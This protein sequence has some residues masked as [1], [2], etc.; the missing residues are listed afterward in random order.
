MKRIGVTAV[1]L[2]SV[3][4]A[5]AQSS[6]PTAAPDPSGIGI[7]VNTSCDPCTVGQPMTFTLFPRT[8]Y[9]PWDPAVGCPGPYTIQPC[10]QLVWNFGDGTV[11]VTTVG[12]PTM[13]HTYATR[14]GFRPSVSVRNSLS[15]ATAPRTFDLVVGGNPATVLDVAGLPPT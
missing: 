8:Y 12:T 3:A 14:G 13:T 2:L 11:P 9:C 5:H 10:D 15:P 1:F 7:G 4:S 6:C